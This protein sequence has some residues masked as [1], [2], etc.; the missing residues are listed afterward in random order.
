MIIQKDL[1]GNVIKSYKSIRDAARETRHGR[2]QITRAIRTG[3]FFANCY[4]EE[5]DVISQSNSVTIGEIDV[6]S[7]GLGYEILNNKYVWKSKENV[8]ELSIELADKIFFE[9]SRHGLDKSSMDVRLRHNISLPHWHSLKHRLQLYKDSD[10]FSPETRKTLTDEEYRATARQKIHELNAYRKKAV[11]D[12]YNDYHIKN[13]KKWRD[14]AN[15]KTFEVE[16][17][18]HQLSEWLEGR[19]NQTLYVSRRE[20]SNTPPLVVATADWHYGAN[21][22]KEYN[23]P[24]YNPSVLHSIIDN[25]INNI[26]SRQSPDVSMLFLGDYIETFSGLNHPNSWQG[27]D[28]GMYGAQVVQS[29]IE[30]LFEPIIKN[31]TNLKRIKAIAGNHDRGSSSNKEDVKGQIATIAFYILQ[32]LYPSIEFEY[33]PFCLSFDLHDIRYILQHGHTPSA[34]KSEGLINDYG[35]Y[36][37]FNLVLTADKHTRGIPLDGFNKRHVKVPSIFTGNFYSTSLG[38]SSTSG[39]L[40]I[41]SENGL[42]Q[43]EDLSFY[44]KIQKA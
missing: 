8:F 21:T 22:S 1:S 13:A 12:E 3:E 5:T 2:R 44:S 42:P 19:S 18:A 33:D 43:I 34:K 36:D 27:I 25:L 35:E 24:Q 7:E 40:I 30:N 14:I 29:V 17:M 20:I 38:F 9:Y 41:R 15:R 26:N 6:T 39:C 4:W 10:I 37:K 23:T 28:K 32:K 11:I 16:S 31:V